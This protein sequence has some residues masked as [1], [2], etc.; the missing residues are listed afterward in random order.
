MEEIG[1]NSELIKDI[2]QHKKYI[3]VRLGKPRFLKI[4]EG[5]VLSIREDL[6]LNGN[7]VDSF[8]DSLRIKITQILYFETLDEMLDSIDYKAAIPSAKSANQAKNRYR[9]FYSEDE[10]NK[11]G[12]VA[13]FFEPIE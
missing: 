9:E 2:K 1:I 5:D 10:E 11:Y 3:E 12:I 6:Y 8:S 4:K 7:I 13:M